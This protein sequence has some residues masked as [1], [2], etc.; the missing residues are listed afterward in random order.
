MC[1]ID[2][3]GPL[4]QSR[5]QNEV[6]PLLSVRDTDMPEQP[7]PQ[8]TGDARKPIIPSSSQQPD[9]LALQQ[10]MN[11]QLSKGLQQIYHAAHLVGEANVIERKLDT[12]TK[13]R[14]NLQRGSS[15]M[16]GIAKM[17]RSIDEAKEEL[18]GKK[19]ELEEVERKALEGLT[20]FVSNIT[21]STTSGIQD[22][23]NSI[24]TALRSYAQ[25][26]RTQH[27]TEFA[28]INASIETLRTEKM[29]INEKQTLMD[30]MKQI[31][32]SVMT[33]HREEVG[34]LRLQNKSAFEELRDKMNEVTSDSYV[35]Q[36]TD[37]IGNNIIDNLHKNSTIK[38]IIS[39]LEH[40]NNEEQK[41]ARITPERVAEIVQQELKNKMKDILVE[42]P[43]WQE[44]KAAVQKTEKTMEDLSK[45]ISTEGS[46]LLDKKTSE[47]VAQLT[48]QV[49]ENNAKVMEMRSYIDTMRSRGL[50]MDGAE[51][52]QIR[53]KAALKRVE[54]MDKDLE[55]LK[56]TTNFEMT[57]QEHKYKQLQDQLD[58]LRKSTTEPEQTEL[59]RKRKRL[60]D[61]DVPEMGKENLQTR[62]ALLE[63]KYQQ[64]VDFIFQF[65]NTVLNPSFPKRLAGGIESLQETLKNHEQ[66][67]AYLVDPIAASANETI[68][69]PGKSKS[70]PLSMAMLQAIEAHTTQTTTSV[71]QPLLV[72]VSALEDQISILKKKKA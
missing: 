66:F 56:N 67:I 21:T 10:R 49:A 34:R 1:I 9:A 5:C 60:N 41:N 61:D 35:K 65:R 13:I 29:S 24:N 57:M 14:G 25:T 18:A 28:A 72:K 50:Q 59:S 64:L 4:E 68:T 27:E 7:A 33:T 46:G 43:E 48:S 70:S 19:K 55:Q 32:A 58:I 2:S 12:L 3:F 15:S 20:D 47:F 39:K 53:G 40:L 37:Q 6:E 45:R 31:R 62:L 54:Q 63:E 44:I 8:T 71:I 30:S 23:K 42:H 36:L 52:E 38:D 16:E 51:Y 69:F 11:D 17:N 26:T 22:L